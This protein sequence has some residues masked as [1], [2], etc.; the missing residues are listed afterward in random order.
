MTLKP[1]TPL[2]LD[3]AIRTCLAKNPDDR[4]RPGAISDSNWSG[5]GSRLA[6][7]CTG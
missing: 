1:L 7:G 5:S 4:W 6:S 3:H 2:A